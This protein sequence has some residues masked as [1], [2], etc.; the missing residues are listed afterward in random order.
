MTGRLKGGMTASAPKRS[1]LDCLLDSNA[2]VWATGIEDT[3]VFEPHKV[4]GRILDEYELTHHYERW[5]EDLDLMATLGVPMARY[6]IPWYRIQLQPNVWDWTFADR[7]LERLLDLGIHP[8]VDLVHY[9]TP[10]WMEG[11]FLN[12][13]FPKYMAEFAARVA[14]RFRGRIWW[15]TPLNEA[16]ITAHYCGRIGWWP[17]FRNGWPGFIALLNA[18]C[19]GIVETERALREVDPEI[20]TLHVDAM[21]MYETNLADLA[22]KAAFKQ[23]LVFLPMDLISGRVNETHSLMEWLLGLKMRESDLQWFADRATLPDL[24]GLNMYPM[25]SRRE[26]TRSGGEVK[27]VAR[28]GNREMVKFLGRSYY[29][30][31]GRPL[32]ISETAATGNHERRIA[33]LYE[34]LNGVRELRA[35]GVPMVGYTWWPMFALIGWAYR[36]QRGPLADYIVPMGLWD[37]VGEDLRR[38]ETPVVEAYRRVVSYGTTHAGPLRK[39]ANAH[40]S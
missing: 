24:I 10:G 26:V 17:P 1:E 18:C 16:R 29:E 11:S 12:P 23:A 28:Y 13:D 39:E 7:T 22:D 32:M 33:W 25:F 5:R 20:V 21:D 14:D 38:V 37:L 35:E 40:V 2:F 19:R 15:Y 34:S 9:G 8:I 3:F 36:Q 31:Y 6:G 30:R 27:Y 4:T